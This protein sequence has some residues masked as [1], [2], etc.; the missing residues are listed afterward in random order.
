M[1]TILQS[2]SA[3]REGSMLFESF[4]SPAFM[5]NENWTLL[6]GTPVITDSVTKQGLYSLVMDSSYPQIQKKFSTPYSYSTVWFYDDATQ[7]ASTFKPNVIWSQPDAPGGPLAF[8]LGVD[9]SVSTG[10]Y[11]A[12]YGNLM[13]PVITTVART[14]GWHRFTMFTIPL[15][16]QIIMLVDNVNATTLSGLV[17]LNTITLGASVY[18]GT[19]F[20]YFDWVQVYVDNFITLYNVQSAQTLHLYLKSSGTVIHSQGTPAPSTSLVQIDVSQVDFPAQGYMAVS[21][22]QYGDQSFFQSDIKDLN[23]GD[24]YLLNLYRFGRRPSSIG[25]VPTETRNDIKAVSGAKQSTFF[26][27]QDTVTLTYRGLTEAQKDDLLRWWTTVKRGETFSVA[28]EESDIFL[29]FTQLPVTAYPVG[30][31]VLSNPNV[32][33]GQKLT[34][35]SPDAE[36]K[37]NVVLAAGAVTD[38]ITGFTT[39]NLVTPQAEAVDAGLQVRA[40]YYWPFAN[41][42]VKSL[43]ENLESVQNSFWTVVIQFEE[44]IQS[45]NWIQFLLLP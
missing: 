13:I 16:A 41:T 12:Y 21:N 34:V 3:R 25:P 5:Q 26:Y 11:V 24:I 35:Q 7:T 9:N 18:T 27:D 20:G 32:G 17:H 1:G 15:S 40:L 4:E 2:L 37:E 38:P 19:P 31:L 44:L 8:S 14:T 23:G 39:V 43:S 22:G 42:T 36:I 30:Q 45:P 10:F 29:D 6:N 33:Q 28:V